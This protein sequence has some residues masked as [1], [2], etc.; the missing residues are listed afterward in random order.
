MSYKPVF[1][2]RD[3]ER[4]GK[5]ARCR[6]DVRLQEEELAAQAM[7]LGLQVALARFL[8]EGECLVDLGKAEYRV[9]EDIVLIE[10]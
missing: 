8:G 3:G 1:I 5:S 7:E 9:L 10:L 4:A 2:F 6:F